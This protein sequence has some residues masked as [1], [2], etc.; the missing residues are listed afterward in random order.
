[1]SRCSTC[2][3]SSHRPAARP[4]PLLRG[5][6]P[7]AAVGDNGPHPRPP[8]EAPDAHE[9]G[10]GDHPPARGGLRG[11]GLR[12]PPPHQPPLL[13]DRLHLRAHRDPRGGP[14][15]HRAPRAPRLRPGGG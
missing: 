1:P 5:G 6:G 7:P 10:H 8:P 15:L 14:T 4:P 12:E 2:S 11:G 9:A 3:A 13:P